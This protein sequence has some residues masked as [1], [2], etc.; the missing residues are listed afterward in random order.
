MIA[1]D[2]GKRFV[3]KFQDWEEWLHQATRV[4]P[5]PNIILTSHRDGKADWAG[6]ET[7][8]EA[9]R[10]ARCGWPEGRERITETREAIKR[11]LCSKI[12]RPE[13]RMADAGDE[14][15]VPVYLSG[16][17][18][19]WI[20]YPI[21]EAKATGGRIISLGFNLFISS[22]VAKELFENRGAAMLAMIDALEDGGYRCE[23]NLCMGA[24]CENGSLSY[25]MTVPVKQPGDPSELDRLAMV[26]IHPAMF[27]RLQFAV[28]ETDT[29][30]CRAA[31]GV[32]KYY[33]LPGR[34]DEA[35]TMDFFFECM[36][37]GEDNSAWLTPQSSTAE[38]LRLLKASGLVELED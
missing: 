17:P 34:F 1:T 2:D 31:F 7:F 21:T 20:E 37:S 12:I 35:S 26:L 16:E 36:S 23:L 3:R 10:L 13:P 14:I 29:G 28:G 6:T 30:A 22:G 27:R 18:E 5:P 15:D 8:A 33:W 19:H 11:V 9:E 38:V 24:A 25:Q 4:A 32:S